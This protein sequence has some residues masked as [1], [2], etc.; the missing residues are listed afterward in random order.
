MT[1]FVTD[2][3]T[4]IHTYIRTVPLLYPFLAY[5]VTEGIISKVKLQDYLYKL[6][7]SILPTPVLLVYTI[8]G[9]VEV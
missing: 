4:H 7:N 6:I 3:R 5:F 8:I 9:I 2:G 1:R